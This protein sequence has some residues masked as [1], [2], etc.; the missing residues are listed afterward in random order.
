MTGLHPLKGI[1][2]A[3]CAFMIFASFDGLS[4][5]LADSQ[6]VI[7]L[8]WIRYLSQTLLL[9][10]WVLPRYGLGVLRVNCP[11]LQIVRG[12]AL[13]SISVF[14][15]F[16]LAQLPL[17]EATA[18]HYL[19]PLLIVLLAVPILGERLC[20]K[21]CVPVLIGFTG[22]LIIVRPSGGLMTPAILLPLSSA[23]CFA[24][25]QLLTRRIGTRDGAATT[26]FVSG[27]IGTVLMTLALP[28]FWDGLPA[29]P[30]LL[31]MCAGGVL[32]LVGHTLLTVA[33][34]YSS[35][36][37][38]APFS[39]LQIFFAGIFGLVIFDHAPSVGALIGMSVIA[40]GGL[41]SA[42]LQAEAHAKTQK[43]A[44]LA[45]ALEVKPRY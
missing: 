28:W 21:Q 33:F 25:Y 39:Y 23:V 1:M 41:Y 14:F 20:L 43:A 30:E 34:Q 18:V 5:Y 24:L 44:G 2:L 7:I 32:A 42:W 26:N 6:N 11:T 29:W 36:V 31:M 13:L 9:G 22:V 40:C 37:L 16:A 3:C 17:A 19:A 38:L 4:K 35:P 15:I 27:L 45:E 8:V 10:I 12:M